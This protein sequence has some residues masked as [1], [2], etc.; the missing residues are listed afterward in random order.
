MSELTL[1]P[2]EGSA[3]R[4]ALLSL[5]DYYL[6]DLSAYLEGEPG[7]RMPESGRYRLPGYFEVY[8]DEAGAGVPGRHAF[9]I[10]ADGELSGFALIRTPVVAGDLDAGVDVHVAEFFVTSKKRRAG[11][12]RKAVHLLMDRFPGVWEVMQLPRNLPSIRFWETV[13]RERPVKR[14]AVEQRLLQEPAPHF[15]MVMTFDNP[16]ATP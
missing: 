3:E 16:P 5:A 13:I 11:A 15:K 4:A 6:Y 2:A 8:W 9:L 10:R 14:F 7:W 1:H 12:G